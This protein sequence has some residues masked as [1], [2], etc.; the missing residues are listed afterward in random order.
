[1]VFVAGA[2]PLGYR[3]RVGRR[4]APNSEPISWHVALGLAVVGAAFIHSVLG[5][6]S[7][8]YPRAIGASELAIWAGVFAALVLM[9]HVG[10]GLQLRNPKLRD[11]TQRRRWHL[12]T[13]LTIAVCALAHAVLL[14]LVDV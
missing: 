14:C 2:I 5:V 1:L 4:A 3:L 6:L 8:G 10:I 7:L 9:A 12:A 13:A 11:R